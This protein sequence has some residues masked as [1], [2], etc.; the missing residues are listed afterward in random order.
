MFPGLDDSSGCDSDT[1]TLHSPPVSPFSVSSLSSRSPSLHSLLDDATDEQLSP[2]NNEFVGTVPSR[3]A[4]GQTNISE[5]PNL[6][7]L[8]ATI[9]ELSA[10]MTEISSSVPLSSTVDSPSIGE[11]SATIQE[12]SATILE[13]SATSGASELTAGVVDQGS[14]VVSSKS[15]AV[16]GSQTVVHP[17]CEP[18]VTAQDPEEWSGF[19]LVGD[20]IDKNFRRS[21]YRHDRKTISMHAFHMYAVKDRIDFSSLSDVAPTGAKVDVTKLLIDQTQVD[22]LNKHVVTLL[23][24]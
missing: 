15:Q 16:A 14:E 10:T 11:L 19:K 1:C 12:L 6:G 13:M 9:G 23:S 22:E 17:T 5:L 3:S 4:I 8:S 21:F 7:D 24:R 20:N 2:V 18:D